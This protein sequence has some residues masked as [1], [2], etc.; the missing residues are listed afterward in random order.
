MSVRRTQDGTIVLQGHCPVEDAELLLQLVQETPA[1]SLD[2]T[3]SVHLHTAVLQVIVAARP[4]LLGP[5]GD[6]WVGRWL[7]IGLGARAGP[8]GSQSTGPNV[9]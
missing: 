4:T 7:G 6:A 9:H 2:W 5:C 8:G 1:A 3:R